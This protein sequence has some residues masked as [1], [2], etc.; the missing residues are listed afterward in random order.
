MGLNTYAFNQNF[1]RYANADADGSGD[2]RKNV[3]DVVETPWQYSL[4]KNDGAAV[5]LAGAFSCRDS[6]DNFCYVDRDWIWLENGETGAS[7]TVAI[8]NDNGDT[9][10]ACYG[11]SGSTCDV[12]SI[13]APTSS[14][15]YI[16]L[17][18]SDGSLYIFDPAITMN[19]QT[20]GTGAF[21]ATA[22][23]SYTGKN[24]FN[25][26]PWQYSVDSGTNWTTGST[27]TAAI[28][29]ML[30]IENGTSFTDGTDTYVVKIVGS[31]KIMQTVAASNCTAL[32]MSG[33]IDPVYSGSDFPTIN[34]G[35]EPVL[36]EKPRVIDGVL[37]F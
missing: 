18:K 32:D 11:T 15:A 4:F 25:D 3:N 27:N 33:I 14:N 2:T 13:G 37:Q 6:S 30:P 36:L 16:G 5:N 9:F 29:R 17:V 35:S 12:N 28:W 24:S 22:S 21:T 23:I 31:E 8:T 34:I 20:I 19:A 1:V 10:T 7:R 26:I